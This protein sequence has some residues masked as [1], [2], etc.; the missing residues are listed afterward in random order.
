MQ[1]KSLNEFNAELQAN[2]NNG[3]FEESIS[4]L[5][6]AITQYP[7]E[8]KLKLNLGNVYKVLGQIDNAINVYTTLLSTSL[9]NIANNN[10]SAIMLETGQIEKCIN[11]ARSALEDD[12]N[13]YDAKYNLALGLFENKNYSES[14]NICND[15]LIEENYRDRAY[16]LKIRVEQII[17]K[18]DYF[19]ETQE[20]LKNNEIIVHPFL[21]VSYVS[22]ESSNCRNAKSWNKDVLSTKISKQLIKT[23]NKIRLGFLCGEIRNHPTY[24][25]IKNLF[26]KINKDTFSMY[27]FSYDH[28]TG[29]KLHIEQDF[30][31]FIDITPLNAAESKDKIKS[32]GLDILIDLTTIISHNRSN[33]IHQDIAKV[34]I[35]YLAFPGTT[36]SHIYDYILTDNVVT[37][38]DKQKYYAEQ[39]MFLPKTYQINN[40]EINID[41]K[42]ERSDFNLPSDGIILGCLNQSFKLDP[43]FFDIWINIMKNHENTYLWLLDNGVE[44]KQNINK[45][46][47]KRIDLKRIIYADRIDYESHLQRIQHIDIALDTRIYNGHTTTTEMIQAG[48]PL[49]TLKGT[50]FASRVSSSILNNLELNDFIT[51]SYDEYER[52]IISLIKQDECISAKNLIKQKINNPEILSVKNFVKD[53]EQAL[54]KCFS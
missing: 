19:S 2:I 44:M 33:I 9:K 25:L 28:E 30:N 40:G 39:F 21:H 41:I 31:E 7:N 43:V 1:K 36:G 45:F 16:E 12:E 37:P 3:E 20:H 54:L 34:I 52:K 42:N 50:H 8:N 23:G 22:D 26:K 46:I 5:S 53:F 4:I 15:L 11:Y 47:A 13:Y 17:C 24:Y 6:I 18:W 14:L 38:L 10:L 35:A 29:K 32:Y 48:I 27:M 49:V 51:E